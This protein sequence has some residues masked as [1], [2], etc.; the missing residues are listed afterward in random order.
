MTGSNVLRERLDAL[1]AKLKEVTASKHA[2]NRW[3][4]GHTATNAELS[5][6]Y[7]DIK[8][9]VDEDVEHEDALGNHVSDLEYSLREW[10]E[11]L[12][13]STD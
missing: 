6:R 7:H 3:H 8:S 13:Y 9:R 5:K 10:L 1:S 11:D 12:N 2:K 4:D